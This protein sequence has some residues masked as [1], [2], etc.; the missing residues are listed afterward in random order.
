[1]RREQKDKPRKSTKEERPG[2]NI[3]SG[4]KTAHEVSGC[5]RSTH[6]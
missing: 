2:V 5:P 6:S 1:M 3:V 4:W